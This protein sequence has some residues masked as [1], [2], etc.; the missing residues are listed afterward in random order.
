MEKILPKHLKM[1]PKEL[2]DVEEHLKKFRK[3]MI[4]G[5]IIVIIFFTIKLMWLLLW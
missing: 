5:M 1:K 2:R 4:T 3:G